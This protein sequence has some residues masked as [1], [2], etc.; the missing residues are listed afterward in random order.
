MEAL[1]R[2]CGVSVGVPMGL[3]RG[4]GTGVEWRHMRRGSRLHSIALRLGERQPR[5]SVKGPAGWR[6]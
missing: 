1:G 2:G 6:G 5:H 4:P 3:G